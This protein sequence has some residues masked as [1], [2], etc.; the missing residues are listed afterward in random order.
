M[1]SVRV[2]LCSSFKRDLEAYLAGR[3]GDVPVNALA[4]IVE[5]GN[6]HRSVE[7]RLRSALDDGDAGAPARCA[8]ADASAEQFRAGLRAAIAEHRLD[9][10]VYPTWSNPPR[11][12][13]D[14]TTPAGDN[15]QSPAPPAG[16]PAITVPM[17]WVR[18]TLPTGLQ[19]LGDA[20]SEPRLIA[21][22]YAYEQ[23]T[24][25]RRPPASTPALR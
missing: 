14:L 17:G 22:A 25:H 15:S 18:G 23:A 1:D 8:T 7:A 3:G 12:V 5:S 16:F 2:T 24:L 13:G 21:L 9:A 10:M 11:L 20:W 6:F 4:Q 19:F